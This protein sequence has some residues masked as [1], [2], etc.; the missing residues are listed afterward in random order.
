[1][2]YR[3]FINQGREMRDRRGLDTLVVAS[4]NAASSGSAMVLFSD[5]VGTFSLYRET[6]AFV[7]RGEYIRKAE[8]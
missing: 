5:L 1:V 3:A 4:V 2:G 6:K 7:F 8:T